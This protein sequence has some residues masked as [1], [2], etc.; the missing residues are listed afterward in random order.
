MKPLSALIYVREN[1]GRAGIAIFLL[2]LTTL[3]FLA[4]NYID[5]IYYY[6]DRAMDYSDQL[7][8]VNWT[9]ADV[10]EQDFNDY[11]KILEA[12]EK[13]IVQGKS[14]RGYHGL[15]WICTMGFEMGSSAMVFN[16]PEDLKEAFDVF[17]IEAD[18]SDVTDKSVCIS[19][20]LARQYGLKKGDALDASVQ[21]GI[22]GSYVISAIL[23]DDS[24]IVFYVDHSVAE[25]RLNV[26]SRELKGEELRDYLEKLRGDRK[27]HIDQTVR[28]GVNEQF[29]PFFYIFGAGIVLLS[30]VL[31]VI[32]N[33]VITGQ[34]AARTY[35]FGVYRAIGISKREIYG[36]CAREILLM[37]GI[38]ILCGAV[39]CFLYT[40]LAN[41]LYYLP[42]GRYL[43]Y[44]SKIGLY[45]FV[46]SNLLVVVPTI[47][48]KG[49]SMSRADVT[50]F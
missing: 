49:K 45:G 9:S 38:A 42:A 26:L 36:K 11:R 30:L 47:L 4:G 18:L 15:S 37:D 19:S 20:A 16:S 6:W 28:S 31:S 2:F 12:D 24:F 39:I 17:G 44:G 21:E 48:L 25:Y 29:E 50:E 3:L 8:I 34:Y 10:D 32:V 27:V 46:A 33:S 43:P 1:K 23:E 7:C 14:G 35:E 5:S 13:L 41:E 40:F 22:E